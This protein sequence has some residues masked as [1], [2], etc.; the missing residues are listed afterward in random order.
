VGIPGAVA[1]AA[2]G[3]DSGAAIKS[4]SETAV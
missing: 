2:S 1:V 4:S 3:A